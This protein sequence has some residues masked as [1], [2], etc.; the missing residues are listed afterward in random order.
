MPHEAR[1][2]LKSLD[3]HLAIDDLMAVE[4]AGRDHGAVF[5]GKVKGILGSKVDVEIL[6]GL[7]PVP[8]REHARICFE[9]QSSVIAYE[10]SQHIARMVDFSEA[11]IGI[12]LSTELE[13][14]SDLEFEL[15]HAAE[16]S[17]WQGKVLYCREDL[18]TPGQFRAGIQVVGLDRLEHSRW[19]NIMNESFVQHQLRREAA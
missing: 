16:M 7:T 11:G 12:R 9:G 6:R 15:R 18:I 10:G 1:F 13:T 2:R 17:P 8:K 5:I 4:L 14:G 19:K 3:T